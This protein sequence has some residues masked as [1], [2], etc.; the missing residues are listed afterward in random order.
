MSRYIGCQDGQSCLI[1]AADGSP[2]KQ[3]SR[4]L[5]WDWNYYMSLI[6]PNHI[7]VEVIREENKKIQLQ[8]EGD[9]GIG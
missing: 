6:K 9:S 5:H 2:A 4:N 1:G 8:D 3:V 7:K